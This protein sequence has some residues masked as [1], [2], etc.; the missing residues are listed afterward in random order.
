LA[1]QATNPKQL[2]F[3]FRQMSEKEESQMIVVKDKPFR[4]WFNEQSFPLKV[5]EATSTYV[6]AKSEDRIWLYNTAKKLYFNE[7]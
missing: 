1:D 6:N 5:N 7:S 2:S 4:D 3:I